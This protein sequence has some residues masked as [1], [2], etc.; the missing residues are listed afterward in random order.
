MGTYA[1]DDTSLH[2]HLTLSHSGS[3]SIYAFDNTA[4]HVHVTSLMGRI[5]H[6]ALIAQAHMCLT[7]LAYTTIWT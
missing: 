7:I 4:L 3:F 2:V 5:L 6:Y 1:L